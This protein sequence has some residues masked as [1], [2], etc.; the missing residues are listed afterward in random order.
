MGAGQVL[1]LCRER[2]HVDG[3]SVARGHHGCVH[4]ETAAVIRSGKAQLDGY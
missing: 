1:W 3:G 2:Q 4:L